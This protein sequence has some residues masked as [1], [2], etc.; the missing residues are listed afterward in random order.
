MSAERTLLQAL[1]ETEGLIVNARRCAVLICICFVV[2][3]LS[4]CAFWT[5]LVFIYHLS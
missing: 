1:R 3:K 4:V 5:E 2:F